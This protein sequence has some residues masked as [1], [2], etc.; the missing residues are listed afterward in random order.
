[1]ISKAREKSLIS[2]NHRKK[3]QQ[4]SQGDRLAL[5]MMRLGTRSDDIDE[6]S[7]GIVI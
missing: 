1:M 5:M 6:F 4:V 3:E 2:F 7:K